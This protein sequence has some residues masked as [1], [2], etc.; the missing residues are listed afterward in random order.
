MRERFVLQFKGAQSIT[1]GKAGQQEQNLPGD[2]EAEWSFHSQEAER[3][4]AGSDTGF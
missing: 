1:A 2:Q 4:K 3:E